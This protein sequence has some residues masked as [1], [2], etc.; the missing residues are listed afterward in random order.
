MVETT[1]VR[2]PPA[3]PISRRRLM[4]DG[5]A[6]TGGAITMVVADPTAVLASG[7][8]R[9]RLAAW[10]ALLETATPEAL[11]NY[12]P[13]AL[14]ASELATLKA[15]LARLIPA[16]DLGPGAVEAGVFVYIDRALAGPAA[17]SLS[18]YQQGLAAL[19]AA[20]SD[21]FV[22][23]GADQQDQILTEAEGGKLANAPAGFF[24]MLLEHTRQGMFGDP[25]YGGNA[26]F[27]GWDLIGYPGIK[28]VWTANEQAIGTVVTPVHTSVAK[29]GGTAS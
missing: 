28:L 3:P 16:D 2:R 25:I 14:T 17:A 20:T 22:S 18:V 27:A 24:A 12:T 10:R 1:A 23:L 4:R 5:A 26:N 11:Q 15:A 19:D 9:A 29:Y 13:V 8:P 21:P 6:L 7:V